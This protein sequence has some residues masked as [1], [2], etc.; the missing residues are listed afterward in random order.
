MRLTKRWSFYI[1]N[2]YIYYYTP[3]P[4]NLANIQASNKQASNKQASKQALL[5][6]VLAIAQPH[7]FGLYST[8]AI[9]DLRCCPCEIHIFSQKLTSGAPGRGLQVWRCPP[10]TA[11][12][13]PQN[14]LI[15]PE[16]ASKLSQNRQMTGN[17]LYIHV[18]LDCPVTK[19]T[20]VPPMSTI[21][22]RNGPKVAKN[23]PNV[24]CLSQRGP[25][26]R[27]GRILGY[28]AQNQIPKAPSPPATPQF[29]L[30]SKPQNHPT[31]RLEPRTSG[32]LVQREGSLA[33]APLGPTVGPPGSP[34]RKKRFFS[35]LFLDHWG[36]SKQCFWAVLSPWWRI[37]GHGKSQNSSKMGRSMTKN[38][39]KMGQKRNFP[40]VIPD[41]LGCSSNCFLAILSPW[42]RVLGHGKSQ[43]ALK[44]GCFMTKNGSKMG[45]KRNF[46]KVI[47]D[48][49]G[50]SN[51]CF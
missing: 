42:W 23:G 21:C 1:I 48:H 39:S 27:T 19:S 15:W 7:R 24:R 35:K 40:K 2:K 28:V 50:S 43:N 11:H 8:L 49:L 22:P 47:L 26:P 30:F 29:L 3:P 10:K 16:T 14:S 9:L 41:H 12:F 25:K 5:L 36:C 38:G 33:G 51:K 4:L 34:G 46:P 31:R 6:S 45:Q 20:L 44:M 17:S 37:L 32:H 13:V 18:R